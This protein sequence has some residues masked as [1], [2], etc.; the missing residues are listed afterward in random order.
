MEKPA[1]PV[2]SSNGALIHDH[3]DLFDIFPSPLFLV[4]AEKGKEYLLSLIEAGFTDIELYLREHPLAV[5]KLIQKVKF[6][7]VNQASVQ[8][9]Q[10]KSKAQ[11]LKG[12][13]YR[14]SDIFQLTFSTDLETFFEEK[15]SLDIQINY[16]TLLEKPL[17]LKL[18][19]VFTDQEN[20]SFNKMLLIVSDMSNQ[21]QIEKVQDA[22][23]K[24]SEYTHEVRDLQELYTYIHKTVNKLVLAK[25]F[26]IALADYNK[27]VIE[28]PYTVDEY[29][30]RPDPLP[31][32]QGFTSYVLKTGKPLLA[33]PEVA[34]KLIKNGDVISHG[35][36]SVDWLG[37][38]LVINEDIIGVLTV[39]TYHKNERLS[40]KDM[41]ILQF[42]STQ[43]AMAIDRKKTEEEVRK[44]KALSDSANYGISIIDEEG[45]YIYCNIHY[46]HM[47]GVEPGDI[48]GRRFPPFPK[49][50]RLGRVGR[51][52]G[53]PAEL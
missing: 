39:Q 41:E 22:I 28:F 20:P 8:F 2:I 52:V 12:F 48:I 32:G 25:N 26:F 11:L 45:K 10:A 3:L 4:D 29:D 14:K 34:D 37:I 42:V 21:V 17:T 53:N 18:K 7:R 23:Y 13:R 43:I 49:S 1:T 19:L 33:T 5:L 6:L 9:Y 38:P 47:H 51:L 36:D 46:A 24:I 31:L 15:R 27:G 16:N 35:T 40:L 50:V 30:A 44:F